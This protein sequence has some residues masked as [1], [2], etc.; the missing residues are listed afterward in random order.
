MPTRIVAQ[1]GAVLEQDTNVAVVD[2]KPTVRVL[3]TRTRR[4]D[5]EVKLSLSAAGT[6]RVSGNGVRTL[7]KRNVA[8][9][10]RA[11]RIALTRS[12]R[13]AARRHRKLKLRV[14]LTAGG[15]TG[16]AVFKIRA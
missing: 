12:G 16:T 1:D 11:F 10:T 14:S 5:L 7:F 9:G 4:R 15:R 2:C 6:V 8:A 3:R 13:A